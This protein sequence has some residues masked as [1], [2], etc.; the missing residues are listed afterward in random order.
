VFSVAPY[1]IYVTLGNRIGRS[2][3]I[4]DAV[5][6]GDFRKDETKQVCVHGIEV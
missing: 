1:T 3:H 6:S 4:D 2:Q 5:T